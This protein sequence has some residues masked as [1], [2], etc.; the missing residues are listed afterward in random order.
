MTDDWFEALGALLDAGARFLVIGAHAMAAHGVPRGTQ[1]LD[2]WVDPSPTNAVRVWRAFAA[3]GAPLKSLGTAE[4]D[5]TRPDTVIQIG[6]AP[7]RIDVLTG[8][9]G[10]ASFDIAWADRLVLSIRG[11]EIPFLGRATLLTNKRASGRTKDAA[12]L[13]ALGEGA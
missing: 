7:N 6:L 5:F 4:A 11:R 3:F 10:V 2:L 8:I 9:S 12:D 13:E 1:D